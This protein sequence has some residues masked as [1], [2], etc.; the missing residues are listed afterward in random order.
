MVY[1]IQ[2]E[3]RKYIIIQARPI[4]VNVFAMHSTKSFYFRRK[5]QV[6][7][8]LTECSSIV[9]FCFCSTTLFYWLTKLAP[10][11]P[12]MGSKRKKQSCLPRTHFP[13]FGAGY[14][15]LLR[16]LMRSLHCVRQLGF[17]GVIALLKLVLRHSIENRST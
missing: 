4:A 5:G 13:A 9:C 3:G 6:K 15:D 14:L 7:D 1:C 11:S 2:L 8:I 12:P 17:A 10:L 16:I